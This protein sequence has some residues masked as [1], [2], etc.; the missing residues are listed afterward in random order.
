MD[1]AKKNT[2]KY[3]NKILSY[4]KKK[5]DTTKLKY[6]NIYGVLKKNQI[7]I[8]QKKICLKKIREC[9]IYK[10]KLVNYKYI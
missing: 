3:K 10:M 8:I 9:F 1:Y 7:F 4:I 6:C 5:F 2:S